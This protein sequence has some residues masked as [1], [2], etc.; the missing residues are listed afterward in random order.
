MKIS[1]RFLQAEAISWGHLQ[2]PAART[3]RLRTAALMWRNKT[4]KTVMWRQP[5]FF[6]FCCFFTLSSGICHGYLKA[7][8]MGLVWEHKD[9]TIQIKAKNFT[10]IDFCCWNDCKLLK[11]RPVKGLISQLFFVFFYRGLQR[12]SLTWLTILKVYRLLEKG[13]TSSV[14]AV[15][16]IKKKHNWLGVFT[17]LNEE[18]PPFVKSQSTDS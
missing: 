8:D 16:T 1:R 12:S 2:A 13:F 6:F 15:G 4:E 7:G 14:F 9:Q 5:V 18:S 17:N 11:A 3:L 10:W